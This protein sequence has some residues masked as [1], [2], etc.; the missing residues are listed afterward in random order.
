MTDSIFNTKRL[1]ELIDTIP[2][3]YEAFS[4]DP[5]YLDALVDCTD[6]IITKTDPL[7]KE[8]LSLVQELDY[9]GFF[10][11]NVLQVKEYPL[12]EREDWRKEFQEDPYKVGYM[13]LAHLIGQY[14]GNIEGN[15]K[16]I[17]ANM[18]EVEADNYQK[19]ITEIKT[20][21]DSIKESTLGLHA[22]LRILDA[23]ENTNY[24]A[25]IT[26]DKYPTLYQELEQLKH[27]RQYIGGD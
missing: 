16:T 10:E 8:R 7:Y 15:V 11:K 22:W 2:P 12:E 18:R 23:P 3:T 24:R 1:D 21:R 25:Q 14:T 13:T 27:T 20:R 5:N 6:K 19:T 4:Q 9:S 26:P 17:S